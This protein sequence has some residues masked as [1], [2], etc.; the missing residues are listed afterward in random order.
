M[1]QYFLQSIQ[2]YCDITDVHLVL[3]IPFWYKSHLQ[4]STQTT[5]V[6]VDKNNARPIKHKYSWQHIFTRD[7]NAT[8]TSAENSNLKVMTA[9]Y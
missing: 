5:Y 4:E 6:D 3:R 8:S 7:N 1:L 2:S 9:D